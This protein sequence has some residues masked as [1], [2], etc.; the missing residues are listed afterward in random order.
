MSVADDI[1]TLMHEAA[2][3]VGGVNVTID[4]GGSIEGVIVSEDLPNPDAGMEAGG[5]EDSRTEIEIAVLKADYVGPPEGGSEVTLS[6]R[7]GVTFAVKPA[8][9]TET[10]SEWRM[11]VVELY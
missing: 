10:E 3:Y 6:T 2:R 8:A 7:T 9:I 11:V 1:L 4:G 5:Y